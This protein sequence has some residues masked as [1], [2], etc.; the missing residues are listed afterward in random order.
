[1]SPSGRFSD[2]CRVARASRAVSPSRLRFSRRLSRRELGL[3]VRREVM[4]WRAQR[5]RSSCCS[6]VVSLREESVRRAL[7]V[8]GVRS[9][10]GGALGWYLLVSHA[11]TWFQSLAVARCCRA[12]EGENIAEGEM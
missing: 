9:M 1:M 3:V 10:G 5:C 4:A 8:S 6:S 11:S 7:R 2:W 12:T